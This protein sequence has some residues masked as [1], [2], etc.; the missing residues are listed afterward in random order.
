MADAEV[1]PLLALNEL[2][3]A[4]AALALLCAVLLPLILHRIFYHKRARLD[5]S[6]GS[7]SLEDYMLKVGGEGG[8]HLSNALCL[9]LTGSGAAR[10]LARHERDGRQVPGGGGLHRVARGQQAVER[11]GSAAWSVSTSA[12]A[13]YCWL[14]Y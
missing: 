12:S 8:L 4:R 6:I 10:R 14:A 11:A 7:G 13:R 3:W 1:A 5:S 2:S 9:P